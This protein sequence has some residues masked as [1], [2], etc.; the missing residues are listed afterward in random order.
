MSEPA[1]DQLDIHGPDFVLDPFPTYAA[2]RD[3]CPVVH[4]DN[5]MQE[6][7]G[8]WLLTRY[9]D[10][11]QAAIDW[12]AFT[13][14][15]PGV[16][17][18]PVITR[19]TEPALPIEV[20]PPVHSRYRALVAPVFSARRVELLRP[21]VA[22]IAQSLLEAIRA[23]GGGDLVA[24]FAMPLSAQTLAAFTGLPPEDLNRWV[25]WIRR[26]FDVAHREDGAAATAEF[27]AYIDAL[28]AARRKAPTDDFISVL[29][30]Q[31]VDGHRLSDAEVQSFAS[32]VFGAGF[33]TTADGLSV[34]LWWLA[35]HALE[36]RALLAQPSAIP[37]AV[38]E[39]LRYSTPIQIFGR[40]ASHVTTL[41]GRTIQ[42]GDVVALAFGSAN[43]DP[44]VFAEP[45]QCRLDRSPN[46]HLT[47]GAGVHLCLGSEVARLEMA[48]TLQQLAQHLPEF[49]LD[50]AEPVEWKSRGDRRGLQ[51]LP[52]IVG[53]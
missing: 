4:A 49:R 5:Y 7:G 13:S 48:V 44:A 26:M 18:I 25:A 1:D 53:A 47:F 11:K 3:R 52:V 17:A 10:V 51:R 22:A 2:L 34:M 31:E 29:L 6:F 27:A 14:R 40:N 41:N 45:A 28:I 35:E 30:S 24:E 15:V 12:R 16:T 32:V 43:Y 42:A 19:R 36:R 8:F 20:D 21:Q 9:A 39:F 46:P 37:P 38:E 33:E 50:P 23:R